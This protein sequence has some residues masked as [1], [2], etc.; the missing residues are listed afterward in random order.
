[1]DAVEN[2]KQQKLI[3]QYTTRITQLFQEINQVEITEKTTTRHQHWLINVHEQVKATQQLIDNR[4]QDNI[5]WHPITMTQHDYP[6]EMANAIIGDDTGKEFNYIQ[7]S[8]HPKHQKYG[9]NPSPT[10]SKD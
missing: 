9:S 6:T 7:L 10:R 8:K 3:H 2:N 1:M 5:I 4:I